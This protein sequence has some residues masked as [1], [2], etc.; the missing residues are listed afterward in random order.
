MD[1]EQILDLYFA[2]DPQAVACTQERYGRKLQA[3]ARNILKNAYRLNSA[4]HKM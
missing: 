2:R 4:H 3:L 1:D